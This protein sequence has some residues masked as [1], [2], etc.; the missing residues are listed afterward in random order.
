MYYKKKY[1]VEPKNFLINISPIVFLLTRALTRDRLQKQ[2]AM[3]ISDSDSH[4]I[5]QNLYSDQIRFL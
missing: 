2:P 4:S 1:I 3:S 5:R